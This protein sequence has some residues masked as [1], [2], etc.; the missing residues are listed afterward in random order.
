MS[1]EHFKSLLFRSSKIQEEIEKERSR[2][3]PNW[4]RLL[5]LK[6]IRLA[7][8]DRIEMLVQQK[9][10]EKAHRVRIKSGRRKKGTLQ[11]V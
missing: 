3:W 11:G 4:M 1:N 5:K 6:K 9:N 8:R 10:S 7:I 2:P